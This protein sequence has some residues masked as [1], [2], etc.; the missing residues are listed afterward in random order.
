MLGTMRKR[1]DDALDYDVS[2]EKWLSPGD[3]LI[4]ATATADSPDLTVLSVALSGAVTKVWLAAGLAG[5]S[6]QITVTATTAQ[7]RVKE[8]AFNLRVVEC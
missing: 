3:T 6:Y 8:V 2:F 7:G 5:N 1:P 4:D